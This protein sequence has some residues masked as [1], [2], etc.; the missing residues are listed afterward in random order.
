MKE[1]VLIDGKRSA[2]KIS[3]VVD[4]VGTITVGELIA[5]L[6]QYDEDTPVILCNDNG[7]TY[8]EITDYTISSTEYGES[9]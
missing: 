4:R 7:Y 2:Y 1:V 6:E 9:D 5:E 3:D 8:G